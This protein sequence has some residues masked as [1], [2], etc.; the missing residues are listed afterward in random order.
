MVKNFP[1]MS[2]LIER[3][4][5]LKAQGATLSLFTCLRL[6]HN[7]V[8]HRRMLKKLAQDCQCSA[9]E[10]FYSPYL[11]KTLGIGRKQKALR[12]RT[13]YNARYNEDNDYNED[14]NHKN[15]KADVRVS[16]ATHTTTPVGPAG[17]AE[18]VFRM[19][20]DYLPYLKRISFAPR[21]TIF[22]KDAFWNGL[23][24]FKIDTSKPKAES[25]ESDSGSGNG[26][27]G[28]G[29]GD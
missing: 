15:K 12:G 25:G 16:Y 13:R 24:A 9:D 18:I 8:G 10:T 22:R 17:A 4:G 7:A 20:K 29:S 23:G 11:S 2:A 21:K 27:S 1:G 19:P 26:G 6:S 14:N 3:E 5:L 28:S